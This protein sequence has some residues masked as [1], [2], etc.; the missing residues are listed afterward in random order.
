MVRGIALCAACAC[1]CGCGLL[2]YGG[3]QLIAVGAVSVR[4]AY[5]YTGGPF[6][7]SAWGPGE[8]ADVLSLAVVLVCSTETIMAYAVGANGISASWACRLS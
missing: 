4:F 2:F 5:L 1:A 3:I 7:L 6:V 8:V